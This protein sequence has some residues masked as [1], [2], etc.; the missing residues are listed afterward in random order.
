MMTVGGSIAELNQV[1]GFLVILAMALTILIM[2][3]TMGI[4]VSTSQAVV[5]AVIGAGL[6]N[7]I[8]LKSLKNVNFKVF[9]RIGIAWVSSPTVAGV[10]TYIVGIATKSYFGA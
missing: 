2:E 6:V 8:K 3:K 5:G 4:P 7:S 1:E 9:V 10:L